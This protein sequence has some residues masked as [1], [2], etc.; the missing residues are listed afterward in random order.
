MVAPSSCL[1]SCGRGRGE[2]EVRGCRH[3][4]HSALP[5]PVIALLRDKLDD[6]A[7]GLLRPTPSS[8]FSALQ[9]SANGGGGTRRL[10]VARKL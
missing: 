1:D 2:G 7:S 6:T 3:R 10:A 4:R 5:R 8:A 9:L